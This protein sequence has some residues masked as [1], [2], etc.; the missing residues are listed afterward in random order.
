MGYWAPSSS[1]ATEVDFLAIR[2][3]QMV[4]IEVKSGATF[5]ETWCRGLRA[6]GTPPGVVRRIVVC[7]DTPDLMLPDGIEVLSYRRLAALLH[8][9]NLFGG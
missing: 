6:F 4:A 2:N 1:L 9:G 8:Q 3:D 7:P 5:N